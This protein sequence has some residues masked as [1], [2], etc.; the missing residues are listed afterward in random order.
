MMFLLKGFMGSTVKELCH[1]TA[2]DCL[3]VLF[4]TSYVQKSEQP[5]L[6][7]ETILLPALTVV[8]TSSLQLLFVKI[9]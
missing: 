5:P 4:M 3:L 2:R 6:E 7:I 9:C 1:V 8:V